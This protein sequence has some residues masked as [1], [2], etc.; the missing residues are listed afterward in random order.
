MSDDSYDDQAQ[1]TWTSTAEGRNSNDGLN[2]QT[3]DDGDFNG[4]SGDNRVERRI[5][6]TGTAA[7]T[8]P[9]TRAK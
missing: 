6:A 2:V 7:T 8:R 1:R 3:A 9:P 4:Q 5:M